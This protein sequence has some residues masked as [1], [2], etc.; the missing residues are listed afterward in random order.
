[1]FQSQRFTRGSYEIRYEIYI[2]ARRNPQSLSSPIDL[3]KLFHDLAQP[4][5]DILH[6]DYLS[7]RLHDPSRSEKKIGPSP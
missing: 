4:L 3:S 5:P 7:V 6:F 2:S 1:M